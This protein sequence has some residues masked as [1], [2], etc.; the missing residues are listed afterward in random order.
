MASTLAPGFRVVRAETLPPEK[1]DSAAILAA[2]DHVDIEV[3][4]M[5]L[6]KEGAFD[7]RYGLNAFFAFGTA[8]ELEYPNGF[9]PREIWEA[10]LDKDGGALPTPRAKYDYRVAS[11]AGALRFCA[12]ERLPRGKKIFILTEFRSAPFLLEFSNDRDHGYFL[13]KRKL[14]GR[15]FKD[16]PVVLAIRS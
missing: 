11:L 5:S 1:S 7:A 13:R 16:Q 8:D 10:G 15:I 14:V 3:S 12:Q 9:A 6:I 2:L 4:L